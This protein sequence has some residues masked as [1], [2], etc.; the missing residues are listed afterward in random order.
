MKNEGKSPGSPTRLHVTHYARISH[1]RNNDADDAPKTSDRLRTNDG[2]RASFR[3]DAEVA[4]VPWNCSDSLGTPT[5]FID[6][7]F[8]CQWHGSGHQHGPL[9]LRPVLSGIACRCCQENFMCF[10]LHAGSPHCCRAAAVAV[11]S[12]PRRLFLQNNMIILLYL[13]RVDID[14]G[15]LHVACRRCVPVAANHTLLYTLTCCILDFS[16]GFLDLPL[17]WWWCTTQH[18]SELQ[19]LQRPSCVR[20]LLVQ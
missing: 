16:C 20:T 6:G 12:L 1:A 7:A 10:S 8:S 19:Q 5:E 14:T 13:W 15:T 2:E 17:M 11:R 4:V 3:C 9:S 18:Y